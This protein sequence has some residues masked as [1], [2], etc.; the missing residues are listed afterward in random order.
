MDNFELFLVF[1]YRSPRLLDMKNFFVG[2]TSLLAQIRDDEAMFKT[3]SIDPTA[4]WEN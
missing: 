3:T 2:E 4:L 1:D